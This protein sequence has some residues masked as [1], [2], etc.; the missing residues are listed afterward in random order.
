[1]PETPKDIARRQVN[2]LLEIS[3]PYTD[4]ADLAIIGWINHSETE[5]SGLNAQGRTTVMEVCER[6]GE[7][8]E[9]AGSHLDL[10]PR[11]AFL[12]FVVDLIAFGYRLGY[13]HADRVHADEACEAG[14]D[15]ADAG[16]D[17]YQEYKSKRD[18]AG[19]FYRNQE[20]TSDETRAHFADA[21]AEVARIKRGEG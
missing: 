2:H 5:V 7:G 3:K 21:M 13:W 6:L 19:T 10:P 11:P 4:S 1:M 14:S 8:Y 12:D 15:A 18:A 20:R 16:E 9:R 17:M